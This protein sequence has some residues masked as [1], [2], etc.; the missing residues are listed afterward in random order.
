[1][2][3]CWSHLLVFV[4]SNGILD[5]VLANGRLLSSTPKLLVRGACAAGLDWARH[6]QLR[7]CGAWLC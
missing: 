5:V 7:V 1:M 6:K 2:V 3:K 4:A